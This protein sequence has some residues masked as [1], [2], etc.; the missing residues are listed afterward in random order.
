MTPSMAKTFFVDKVIS[1]AQIEGG[2]FSEAEKYMLS[3]SESDP[4]FVQDQA[5]NKQ[6][7]NETTD[8]DFEAKIEGLLKRAFDA[9]M[10]NGTT[11]KDRYQEAYRALKKEDHYI[12]V[13]IGAAL[14]SKLKKFWF[15]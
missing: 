13:M 1:Q 6:F 2:A 10:K 3:W 7:K 11:A 8:Q 9:E 4:A 14:G 15:F 12:L 5:L